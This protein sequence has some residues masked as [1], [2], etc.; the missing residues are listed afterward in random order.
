MTICSP[1]PRPAIFA[2]LASALFVSLA[3]SSPA[4]AE[5]P[6][7]NPTMQDV[8]FRIGK[9]RHKGRPN[10]VRKLQLKRSFSRELHFQVRFKDDVRYTTA[11][12][13]NQGDWNKLLGFTT[14]RIHKNSVRLGWAFDPSLGESGEVRLGFYGYLDG[15]RTMERLGSVP[16]N[17]WA[18]VSIRFDT[19]GMSVRVGQNEKVVRG[20]L[21]VADWVPV[22]TWLLRTAYFGGDEKAPHTMHIEVRN[23]VV[24]EACRR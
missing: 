12:P 13:R 16:L 9:D 10:G 4:R 20:D 21:G 17:E 24:D 22:S 15:V 8:T 3:V 7:S 11:D 14:N 1:A 5:A 6:C 19:G 2:L 23:L 18:D